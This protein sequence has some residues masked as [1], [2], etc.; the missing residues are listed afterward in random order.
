M[1]YL[2]FLQLGTNS[3]DVPGEINKRAAL[4]GITRALFWFLHGFTSEVQRPAEN[5]VNIG[6]INVKHQLVGRI[7]IRR[8][9]DHD[10]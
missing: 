3:P 5:G 6:N 2:S 7:L 1:I 4:V 10:Y 8:I 9:A